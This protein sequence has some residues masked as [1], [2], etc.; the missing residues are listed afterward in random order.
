MNSPAFLMMAS[1]LISMSKSGCG[2]MEEHMARQ[3]PT[4]P[5][6]TA[7]LFATVC[8]VGE[9][10]GDGTLIAPSWVLTA[11]H[12]AE[13]MFSRTG[14]DLQVYFDNGEVHAVHRIFLHPD[15]EPMGPHDIALLELD[16]E[17]SGITPAALYT[18]S[19]ELHRPI[20]MAGHGDM[21]MPDG[22]WTR[23][24]RL[25]N[26]TNIV[27]QV[28]DAHLLFDYD[29]PGADATEREGTGGP[30]DSGGPAF[31]STE[32]GLAVAGVSSMGEPGADGPGSYGAR[33]HF[34][35]VS[36]YQEWLQAVM[37]DPTQHHA[38]VRMQF[39]VPAKDVAVSARGMNRHTLG[40]GKRER[41]ASAIVEA[42]GSGKETTL[43]EAIAETYEPAIVE[44][45]T[46]QQI[47]RN[48][49]A[50][51]NELAGAHL[52]EVLSSTPE[53]VSLHLR[54]E[55]VSY[56]LDVFFGPSGHIEQMAFGRLH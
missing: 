30:G 29:A 28:T 48:M 41:A 37:R 56:V 4:A 21:R 46:A 34:V 31:I 38:L 42:L 39:P 15:F 44:A 36:S 53:K 49:P 35:R 12:V 26:Y 50:L 51:M 18:D 17:V 43:V 54:N 11:S 40:Q 55:E 8:K 16:G 1:V 27:D 25:R 23:E 45:R 52:H 47:A 3:D 20:I 6:D 10:G 33:E 24:G 19:D 13:G 14:G 5:A 22:S 9:R 2:R 32:D 7:A